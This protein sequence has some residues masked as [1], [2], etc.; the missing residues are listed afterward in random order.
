VLFYKSKMKTGAIEIG[1]AAKIKTHK[2]DIHHVFVCGLGGSGIGGSFVKELIE[3]ESD[4]PVFV[5]KGYN[6]SSYVGEI[7]NISTF[8]SKFLKI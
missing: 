5:N 8:Y 1:E 6:L 4:I 3:N 2:K 7:Q